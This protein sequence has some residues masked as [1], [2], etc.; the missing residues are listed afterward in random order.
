MR[1][2]LAF[3]TLLACLAVFVL[4]FVALFRP[5]PKLRLGTRKRAFAGF[6]VALV[7]FVAT[8]LIMPPPAEQETAAVGDGAEAQDAQA[9]S[10]TASTSGELTPAQDEIVSFARLTVMQTIVCGGSADLTQE[11]IDKIRSGRARPIDAYQEAKRAISDCGNAVTELQRNDLA[12]RLPAA[13]RSLGQQALASCGQA[14]S[15]RKAAM[16]MVQTILDGDD[17]PSNASEYLDYKT[18]AANAEA[19]CRLYL[20]GLAERAGVPDS[21]VEFAKP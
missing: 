14:A 1:D 3:C 12:D 20:L 5:L 13:D 4:S 17:R 8:A 11:S 15:E 2:F 16:E 19:S 10:T 7:L 6:G 9:D 18:A 21:D